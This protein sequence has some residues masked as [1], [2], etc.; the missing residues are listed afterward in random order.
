MRARKASLKRRV[1]ELLE[2]DQITT[3]E[4]IAFDE[5]IDEADSYDDLALIADGI[6]YEERAYID[7]QFELA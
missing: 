1:D 5:V 4:A 2:L 7:A 3:A 6:A